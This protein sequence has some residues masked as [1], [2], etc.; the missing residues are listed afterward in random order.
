MRSAVVALAAVLC[1]CAPFKS[2]PPAPTW[3]GCEPTPP[4]YLELA[5]STS[6]LVRPDA[7]PADPAES[8]EEATRWITTRGFRIVTESEL[9]DWVR[10]VYQA[11]PTKSGMTL[12]GFVVLSDSAMERDDRDLAALLW[13]EAAHVGQMLDLGPHNVAALYV[14]VP[15]KVTV[16]QAAHGRAALELQA[17]R[18]SYIALRRMGA[19]VTDESL[20]ETAE[21]VYDSYYLAGGFPRDC[22]V[23]LAV[24]LWS[25]D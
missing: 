13:H 17:Y 2:P 8:L 5:E 10:R 6:S 14:P 12:P 20:R 4:D 21:K 3:N 25:K 22:F 7:I 16:A 19:T 24:T 9:P 15:T 11:A 18:Q 1:G 23:D